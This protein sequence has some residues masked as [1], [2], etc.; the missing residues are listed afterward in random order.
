LDTKSTETHSEVPQRLI[1]VLTLS[2]IAALEMVPAHAAWSAY[3]TG[4]SKFLRIIWIGQQSCRSYI[5]ILLLGHVTCI[6]VCFVD[7]IAIFV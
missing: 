2:R 5:L 1:G 4:S 3:A 6:H 7:Y